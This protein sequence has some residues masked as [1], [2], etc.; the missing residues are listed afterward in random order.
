MREETDT[1]P[2]V[3]VRGRYYDDV[4][5]YKRILLMHQLLMLGLGFQ[6]EMTRALAT[7]R[8]D[9]DQVNI[10]AIDVSQN[11]LIARRKKAKN[12]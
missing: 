1:W 6:E 11:P 4:I 5:I 3:Q 7:M 10:K 2:E 9:Y 12:K 8:V